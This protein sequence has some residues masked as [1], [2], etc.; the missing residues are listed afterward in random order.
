M[1]ARSKALGLVMVFTALC[2]VSH[3]FLH[4]AVACDGAGPSSVE[5]PVECNSVDGV[6]A[7]EHL[8]QDDH[9]G[10]RD[11]HEHC[12]CSISSCV[13]SQ[14][15]LPNFPS[16]SFTTFD[17]PRTQL[18]REFFRPLVRYIPTIFDGPPPYAVT[19]LRTIV[20]LI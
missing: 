4:Y 5:C 11:T 14:A 16:V 10:H 18:S 2:V 17:L 13:D 7:H 15:L 6:D 20:F 3:S 12:P 19:I 1:L 9:S 8:G